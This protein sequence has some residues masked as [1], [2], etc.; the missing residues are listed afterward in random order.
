[1]TIHI[2]ITVTIFFSKEIK[3]SGSL[4]YLPVDMGRYTSGLTRIYVIHRQDLVQLKVRAI[5]MTDA[6]GFY[7]LSKIKNVLIVSG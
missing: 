6:V 1:M 7:D 5:C 2:S 3:V 4:A